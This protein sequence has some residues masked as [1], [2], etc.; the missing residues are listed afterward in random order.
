MSAVPPTVASV[1]AAGGDLLAERAAAVNALV[2][3]L[4]AEIP[5]ATG[6]RASSVVAA[7]GKRLRPLLALLLAGDPRDASEFG[8]AALH[9]ADGRAEHAP[10]DPDRARDSTADHGGGSTATRAG[11]SDRPTDPTPDV[12]SGIAAAQAHESSLL[13]SAAAIELVHVATL[14]HDDVL[15]RAPLRRGVPTIWSQNGPVAAT[16]AGDALLAAAFEAVAQHA[17]APVAGVLAAAASSLAAGELM[18]RADA[19]R[20]DITPARYEQR[21]IGKTA[22]LF[23]AACRIGA[24]HGDLSTDLAGG[25]GC[26]LGVAFQML[27]DLLDIEGDPAI[28]GKAR[29]TDLLDGTVTLP[30]ALAAATNPAIAAIDLRSLDVSAADALCDQIIATGATEDVRAQAYARIDSAQNAIAALPGSP[31][32]REALS[33]AAKGLVDRDR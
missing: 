29:G 13:V 25:I 24:L 23:D 8:V 6:E 30:L 27:D 26:D 12:A 9:D 2:A 22:A 1:F 5:G 33:L 11:D 31:A 21:V 4:V 17:E 15:D 14:V 19:Y 10:A 18:Q 3:E 32:R 20:L 28:T 7:G 16:G